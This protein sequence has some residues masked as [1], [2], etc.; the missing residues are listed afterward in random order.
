MVQCYCGAVLL[1]CRLK[2]DSDLVDRHLWQRPL[3][4]ARQGLQ[5]GQGVH[6]LLQAMH[7]GAGAARQGTV[8]GYNYILVYGA[9]MAQVQ[10]G[11]LHISA[12]SHIR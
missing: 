7:G 9:Y 11:A 8:S 10:L 4:V 1:W 6:A 5:L 12:C 3:V 2:V